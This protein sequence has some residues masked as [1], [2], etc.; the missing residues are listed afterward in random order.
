M[1]ERLQQILQAIARGASDDVLLKQFPEV[2]QYRDALTHLRGVNYLVSSKKMSPDEALDYYPELSPLAHP[3][4]KEAAASVDTERPAKEKQQQS[5]QNLQHI[6]AEQQLQ[7]EQDDSDP[8]G[9]Y[10]HPIQ[11]RLSQVQSKK[12]ELAGLYTGRDATS[13]RVPIEVD[14]ERSNEIANLTSQENNLRKQNNQVE[15]EFLK[16]PIP[17]QQTKQ[18]LSRLIS[19]R[20]PGVDN[21]DDY[22]PEQ[23]SEWL[24]LNKN[25]K[26][27]ETARLL[28]EKYKGDRD[29]RE[30]LHN[31]PTFQQAAVNYAYYKDPE[32]YKQLMSVSSDVNK[33]PP[34]AMGTVLSAFLSDPSLHQWAQEKP[35]RMQSLEEAGDNLFTNYPSFGKKIIAQTLAN[36][37]EEKGYNNALVNVL[38]DS[39]DPT[40][41]TANDKLFN[42][43]VQSGELPKSSLP[44]YKQMRGKLDYYISTPGLADN[45]LKGIAEGFSDMGHFFSDPFTSGSQATYSALENQYSRPNF[46]PQGLLHDATTKVG[47]F[48][49][50]MTPMMLITKGLT[51]VGV[52]PTVAN[53]ISVG[54]AFEHPNRERAALLFPNSTAQQNLYTALSTA[55]DMGIGSLYD[56]SKSLELLSAEAKPALSDLV[57]ELSSGNIT[58]AAAR[59]AAQGTFSGVLAKAK[60]LGLKTLEHNVKQSAQIAGF[61][62]AHNMLDN[63]FGKRDDLGV[64]EAVDAGM[65]AFLAGPLL[66]GMAALGEMHPTAKITASTI[67]DMAKNPDYYGGVINRDNT[68]SEFGRA[69][70]LTNLD[71]AKAIYKDLGETE[72][73]DKQK[74]N[75]L[76][77]SLHEQVLQ[78][79]IS[80]TSDS[81]FKD[82]LKEQIKESKEVR[83]KILTRRE[84]QL[85]AVEDR[86]EEKQSESNNENKT[87]DHAIQEQSAGALSFQPAPG[88]SQEVGGGNEEKAPVNEN[89]SPVRP[90]EKTLREQPYT[91]PSGKY[92]IEYQQGKRVVVDTKTN[93]VLPEYIGSKKNKTVSDALRQHDENYNYNFGEKADPSKAPS[94][95]VP[96]RQI[97]G[98][99]NIP[100]PLEV[101]EIYHNTPKESAPLSAKEQAIADHGIGKVKES[102][103]NEFGDP[104]T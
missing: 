55:L 47:E 7:K 96:K 51:G 17:P 70:R 92:R 71:R 95:A 34:A 20:A 76:L 19:Q 27:N 81:V 43:L 14:R 97:N 40:K 62:L 52:A 13:T 91:T 64:G 21:I 103:Y 48:T 46:K 11:E 58:E 9:S 32:L 80:N 6:A 99:W 44:L 88:H 94:L 37:R 29:V 67:F 83:E 53:S 59:K 41:E 63:A 75:Y 35:E 72:L 8:I 16:R 79:K 85:Q 56:R 25:G 15:T 24:P 36:L 89:T 2:G 73:T 68:V 54:L 82:R 98:P 61:T 65:T 84:G 39:S 31:A 104:I 90:E 5:V 50:K 38:D 33:L 10:V 1:N 93:E 28:F 86:Q 18:E 30:S 74:K 87:Q 45:M 78:D 77:Q 22:S 3:A 69:E 4:V 66:S 102:S 57:K 42:Q 23:I 49:G 101:A 26:L 60:E 100:L 12:N